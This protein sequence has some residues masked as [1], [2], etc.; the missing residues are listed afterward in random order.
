MEKVYYELSEPHPDLVILTEL[1]SNEDFP[2]AF[3]EREIVL[4]T[5]CFKERVVAN[6]TGE[7]WD[8]FAVDPKF[9]SVDRL[10]KE[11]QRYFNWGPHQDKDKLVPETKQATVTPEAK[12]EPDACLKQQVKEHEH[13]RHGEGSI[14]CRRTDSIPVVD[15][16]ILKESGGNTYET[17]EY[18]LY[19]GYAVCMD[20]DRKNAQDANDNAKDEPWE[21]TISPHRTASK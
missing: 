13:G 10:C 9:V 7:H 4:Y 15:V 17:I 18:F 1:A 11:S 5:G 3:S 21:N 16:N 20:E 2:V 12:P 6:W 14:R 19:A 8:F